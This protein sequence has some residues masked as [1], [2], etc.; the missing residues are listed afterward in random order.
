L[1]FEGNDGDLASISTLASNRNS[2]IRW[3]DLTGNTGTWSVGDEFENNA[4]P[5]TPIGKVAKVENAGATP[6]LYY[7]HSTSRLGFPDDIANGI[8]INNLGDTGT[9]TTNGAS[10]SRGIGGNILM[11]P[12]A[13]RRNRFGNSGG[14][15]SWIGFTSG[16]GIGGPDVM[17]RLT[18]GVYINEGNTD[19]IG[20]T[21]YLGIDIPGHALAT[22]AT[23]KTFLDTGNSYGVGSQVVAP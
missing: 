10:G 5:G 11:R 7:I 14:T 15:V 3:I 20:A 4:S 23:Y 22:L 16:A 12:S 2:T 21:E 9:G 17:D 1:I 13:L 19:F 6:R 18:G 8:T